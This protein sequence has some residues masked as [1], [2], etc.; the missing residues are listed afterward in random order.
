MTAK[1]AGSAPPDGRFTSGD[2]VIYEIFYSGG[3]IA[4]SSFDFFSDEG[5]GQ[6]TFVAAARVQNTTGPGTGGSGWIGVVPEPGTGA[7]VA[8]GLTALAVARQ[9]R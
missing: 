7:L 3:N 8:L 5:A 4:A 9:R 1:S 6:G 2:V